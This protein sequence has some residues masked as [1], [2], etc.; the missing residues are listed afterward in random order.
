M[1]GAIGAQVG[2]QHGM[3]PRFQNL[4]RRPSCVLA[5]MKHGVSAIAQRQLEM[6]LS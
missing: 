2:W 5:Y 4:D 6:T 3:D 1:K